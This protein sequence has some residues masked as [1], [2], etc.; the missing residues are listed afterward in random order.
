MLISLMKN[1]QKGSK[2]SMQNEE[3]MAPN[4]SKVG[5]LRERDFFSFTLQWIISKTTLFSSLLPNQI[6]SKLEPFLRRRNYSIWLHF[7]W[8]I[9]ITMTIGK[10][11]WNCNFISMNAVQ[12]SKAAAGGREIEWKKRKAETEL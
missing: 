2:G 4:E 12:S 7:Y 10:N 1:M 3:I 8:V 11:E 6:I 9:S 5:G